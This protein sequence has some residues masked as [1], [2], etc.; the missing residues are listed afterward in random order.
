MTD[1][2]P[3]SLAAALERAR[4]AYPTV[5]VSDSDFAEFLARRLAPGEPLE[6]LRV[7]ALYLTCACARGDSGALALFD[8]TIL[9]PQ[10]EAA[11]G[12]IRGTPSFAD[13][14]AEVLRDRL[15]VPGADRPA[16]IEDYEGRGSLARWVHA[17]ALRAAIDALRATRKDV[18]G[19]DALAEHALPAGDAELELIKRR[20]SADFKAAVREAVTS[21]PPDARND[22]RFY[23]IEGLNLEQLGAMHG[24]G[25]SSASR[26]L[27]KARE[28]V[29]DRTRAILRDRLGLDASEVASI[30]RVIESRLEIG[31]SALGPVGKDRP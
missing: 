19:D 17:V 25:A 4:S 29:L 15:L 13:E 5:A 21:L 28:Q 16:R 10:V 26:R 18:Q 14:I 31:A 20:Y 12:R 30:L 2:A 8:R 23:Y 27:A 9:R 7:E 1:V 22:L 24:V 11:V 6:A 3:R